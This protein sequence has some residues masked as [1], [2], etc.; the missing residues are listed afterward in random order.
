[1]RQDCCVKPYTKEFKRLIRFNSCLFTISRGN[2]FNK[3]KKFN[4]IYYFVS[5]ETSFYRNVLDYAFVSR[6]TYKT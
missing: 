2:Y 4:I 6:E 1:M 5:R 3:A